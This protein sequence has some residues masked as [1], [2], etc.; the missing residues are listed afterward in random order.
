[1]EQENNNQKSQIYFLSSDH[2]VESLAKH[3]HLKI[4]MIETLCQHHVLP[5]SRITSAEGRECKGHHGQPVFVWPDSLMALL[6]FKRD[7][8]V[9]YYIGSESREPELVKEQNNLHGRNA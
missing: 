5:G 8:G 7:K 3:S 6:N 9:Q 1:M 4:L 2:W